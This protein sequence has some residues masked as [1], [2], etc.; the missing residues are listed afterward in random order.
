MGV[1][2]DEK[3]R[4]TFNKLLYCFLS[5]DYVNQTDFAEIDPINC[6]NHIPTLYLGA[7]ILNELKNR[8]L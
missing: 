3:M 8:S 6:N 2:L 7:N 1:E 5:R 4:L